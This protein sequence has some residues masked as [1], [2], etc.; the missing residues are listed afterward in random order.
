MLTAFSR[1]IAPEVF[2]IRKFLERLI[3]AG[4]FQQ[5]K[6]PL[7]RP[8]KDRGRVP[9]IEIEGIQDVAEAELGII[10]QAAAAKPPISIGDRP[11]DHIS[12]RVMIEV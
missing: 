10:V 6:S 7:Q 11:S 4:R 2:V 12:N 1:G 5:R 9:H 3:V 8:V